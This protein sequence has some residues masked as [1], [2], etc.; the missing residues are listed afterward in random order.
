M[1]VIL[2][3]PYEQTEQ[4]QLGLLWSPSMKSYAAPSSEGMNWGEGWEKKGR[5]SG[6][7]G[8]DQRGVLISLINQSISVTMIAK[9][10]TMI[11]IEKVVVSL[12]CCF[13]LMRAGTFIQY[14]SCLDE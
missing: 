10:L 8:R 3:C 7:W 4:T 1:L 13:L 2:S 5:D 9:Y 14:G 6:C 11:A 12:H